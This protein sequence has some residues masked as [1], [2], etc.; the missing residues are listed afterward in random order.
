[1]DQSLTNASEHTSRASNVG[2]GKVAVVT[3]GGTGIGAATAKLLAEQ[4]F[5]VAVIGR[6][7]ERLEETVGT[8]ASG[9][10]KGIPYQADVRDE[11]RIIEIAGDLQQRYDRVDVLINSA[12]GQFGAPAEQ[13]SLNGWQAVIGVNLTGTFIMCR[14]LLPLMK[15][16]GSAIVNV[17]ADIWQGAAVNMAHSGAARA[18]VV[19]LTRTLAVEWAPYSIRVN[20]LSPGFTDTEGFRSHGQ[21]LDAAARRAP[22]GRIATAEE[23]ARAAIWLASEEA[24]YITG[25]VLVID[26]GFALA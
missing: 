19:S 17:V 10:G 26:G 14:T 12:G 2:N 5:T 3:G 7:K 9:G 15:R 16:H 22:L 13:I 4:G 6:R 11:E 24:S 18:G 21:D 20:A 25:D 1:M 23:V 8:V